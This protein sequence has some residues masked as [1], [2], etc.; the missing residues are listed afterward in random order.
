MFGAQKDLTIDTAV[1]NTPAT[2]LGTGP[3]R[4]NMLHTFFQLHMPLKRLAFRLGF[5]RG[6]ELMDDRNW[7]QRK[8]TGLW[9]S[10][11]APPAK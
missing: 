5:L 1:A 2:V 8:P 11:V 7:E 9:R 4:A 6:V 10:V 3:G